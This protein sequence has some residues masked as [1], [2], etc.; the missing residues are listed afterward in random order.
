[1][2]ELPDW[3]QLRDAGEQIK[4]HAVNHLDEHLERLEESVTAAGGTVHW[5]RD[6]AEANRIVADL[7]HA[8]GSDEVVKV[9]SLTT[10]E[11]GLN[12]ALAARGIDAIETDLA[13]LIVQLDPADR[14]SHILVPAIHR[15]RQE[16]R[17]LFAEHLPGN[18]DISADP[19]R[20]DRRGARVPAAQVPDR[21]GRRQRGQ[22]R[23]R[24]DRLGR[25]GGVRGQRAHVHHAPGHADHGHGH[26]EGAA[27]LQR[28]GGDAAA[29]AALRRRP[30]A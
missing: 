25:R 18:E 3:E 15:N 21:E 30:S 20:P 5:A 26:R 12:D 6:G 14:Q 2:A 28:P 11:T 19:A 10:D 4:A 1:M 9:K 27:P 22:L 7:T 8:A 24:R 13:E 23:H 29:A 16:I 17:A